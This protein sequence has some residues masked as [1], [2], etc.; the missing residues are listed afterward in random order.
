MNDIVSQY[1]LMRNDR[2]ETTV[3]QQ[4]LMFAERWNEELR[5]LSR[6]LQAHPVIIIASRH[7]AMYYG[8]VHQVKLNNCSV[9]DRLLFSQCN[10][11]DIIAV[12]VMW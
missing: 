3:P 4:V 7:E 11:I 2:I 9:T 5:G 1:E 6:R 12:V 10:V 8:R